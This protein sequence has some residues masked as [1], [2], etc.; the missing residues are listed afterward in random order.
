LEEDSDDRRN[1]E[2]R[3]EG[4]EELQRNHQ[5]GMKLSAEA[6][7]GQVLMGEG[8]LQHVAR[9]IDLAFSRKIQT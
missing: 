7:V 8:D 9:R 1:K 2:D 3:E 5:K 4:V 6:K